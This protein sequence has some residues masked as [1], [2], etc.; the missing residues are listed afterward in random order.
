MIAL[1]RAQVKQ[2]VGRVL[3][4]HSEKSFPVVFDLVDAGVPV[5]YDYYQTRHKLYKEL[6]A[7]IISR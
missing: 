3:R 4:E 6:G 7:E 2:T 5:L 1:P